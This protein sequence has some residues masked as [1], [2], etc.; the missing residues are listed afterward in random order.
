M[1]V[2]VDKLAN[3]LVGELVNRGMM[4]QPFHAAS[5]EHTTLGKPRYLNNP[6]GTRYNP[7]ASYIPRA[8]TPKAIPSI[9]RNPYR[10]RESR[11]SDEAPWSHH[12][13]ILRNRCY[14][15]SAAGEEVVEP[16]KSIL[17]EV[18]PN[19]DVR[20]APQMNATIKS[21]PDDVELRKGPKGTVTMPLFPISQ[22]TYL[23]YSSPEIVIFEARYRQMY[24][25]ILF[26]GARRFM[27][28]NVDWET[29]RLA[30]VGAILYLNDI[31]EISEETQDL[32]K[33][34]GRHSVIGRAKLVK[35]LNPEAQES[36]ETYLRAEV[37]E[38][39]DVDSNEDTAGAEARV[40][41]LFHDVVDLQG[42]LQ[43]DPRLHEEVKTDLTFSRGT[44]VKDQGLWG[45]SR[46]WQAFL[47]ERDS[48]MN[49]KMQQEVES[50][51]VE[52]FSSNENEADFQSMRSNLDGMMYLNQAPEKLTKKLQ[53]IE[54]Q[55]A[56]EFEA[57]DDDPD[58]LQ[59]QALLQSTS[60]AERLSI[61]HHI[62]D[63]EYKRLAACLALQ[64]MF[65][66]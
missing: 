56:E 26:N 33:Y 50:E 39:E 21:S 7:V 38:L 17:G 30:E 51:V 10:W 12:R 48:L 25:D 9:R 22:A 45:I 54:K 36:K 28:C 34:V 16:E 61:F 41:K 60:H 46:L 13:Q 47:E 31:K 5:L 24:D 3:H 57:R 11:F 32:A 14:S 20:W 27:V 35:V 66:T 52:Y 42:K 19:M 2:V 65:K 43:E 53:A 55:Y 49:D 37:E 18:V 44:S 62:V 8:S 59:F 4:A 6:S 23:P 1:N 58:G 29:G 15:T 63:K 64:S 40:R